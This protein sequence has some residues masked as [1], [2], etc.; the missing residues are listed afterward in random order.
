MLIYNRSART[1]NN[2][3]VKMNPQANFNEFA[4]LINQKP[5]QL[6]FSLRNP[7]R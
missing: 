1:N 7:S 4:E 2:L 6:G 5:M 3:L